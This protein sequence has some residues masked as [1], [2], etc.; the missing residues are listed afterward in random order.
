MGSG[1]GRARGALTRRDGARDRPGLLG[2]AH[3][4]HIPATVSVFGRAI[5]TQEGRRRWYDVPL[6]A[7]EAALKVEDLEEVILHQQPKIRDLDR[8]ELEDQLHLNLRAILETVVRV[9]WLLE[10]PQPM[11]QEP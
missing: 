2:A 5:A 7:A 8:E 9:L 10:F 4:Q 6:T 1:R 11:T 3:A